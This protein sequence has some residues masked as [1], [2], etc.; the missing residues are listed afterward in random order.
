MDPRKLSVQELLAYCLETQDPDAWTEFVRRTQPLIAGVGTKCVFRRIGRPN[1]A[2]VD[3]LVQDTYLKLCANNF[4]A[5]RNF[6]FRHENAFFGFLKTVARH[7]V[8]D[9]FRKPSTPKP[10]QE[11]DIE[12]VQI[13]APS[14]DEID[15][16]ERAVLLREIEEC[17]HENAS[18]TNFIRDYTFFLLYFRQG[19]TAKAVSQLPG[20]DLDVKGVESVLMRM[21]CKLRARLAIPRK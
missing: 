21:I 20:I 11:E 18:D 17:V 10:G 8:E 3:D 4:K 16:A 2:L 1:P 15:P 13:P 12:T 5:L 7:V 19:L 6:V 14:L 9:H